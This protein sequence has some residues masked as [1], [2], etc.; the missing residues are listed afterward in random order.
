MFLGTRG[1]RE[2]SLFMFDQ[3]VVVMQKRGHR[4][5]GL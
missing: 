5:A 2:A 4:R 3:F 1:A